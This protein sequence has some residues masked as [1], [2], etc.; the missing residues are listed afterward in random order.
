MFK[1]FKYA[2]FQ[3]VYKVGDQG[4][5]IPPFKGSTFRGTF[6]SVLREVACTCP[7]DQKGIASHHQVNCI[8]AYLFETTGKLNETKPNS[9]SVPRPF[10]FEPPDHKKTFFA[11]G[12]TI[13]LGFSLF[14]K[15]IEYL[16]Y[17]IFTL[18]Q[19]GERGIG[20]GRH[21][22]ELLQVFTVD[23]DGH[24]HPIYENTNRIIKNQFRVYTGKDIIQKKSSAFSVFDKLSLYFISPTRLKHDGRYT[25]CPEFHIILRTTVRRITSLLF[26]HHDGLK[27][28]MDFTKLFKEAESVGLTSFDGGWVEWDRYSIRQ[29][30]WLKM[31]GIVG[32]ANYKGD[33][34]SYTPWLS[35]AEHTNI[36]KNATFG[37]GRI[38]T[39]FR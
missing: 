32:Q 9:D 31:G 4:L 7:G 17:F 23:L 36:G 33:L 1:K 28:D 3:V 19:L 21:P 39:V 11:P 24:L 22:L 37:L 2:K 13:S 20:R 5:N 38:S 25:E 15:G 12:E 16:P 30:Q 8:Y 27:L 14:G 6:G 10:L 34:V 35:L 29:K 18:Q 26:Y